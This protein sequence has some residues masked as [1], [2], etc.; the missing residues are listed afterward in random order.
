MHGKIQIFDWGDLPSIAGDHGKKQEC[1][2]KDSVS[3][4]NP[5]IIS[6][7]ESHDFTVQAQR[8]R[9]LYSR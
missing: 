7:P 2:G 9:R 6:T 1:C 5:G 3:S 8:A 4:Q